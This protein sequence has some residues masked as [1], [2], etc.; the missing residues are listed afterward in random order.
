MSTPR[1]WTPEEQAEADR[2]H[3]LGW[4]DNRIARKIGRNQSAVLGRRDYRRPDIAARDKLIPTPRRCLH[5]GESFTASE[6]PSI[7]RI[8]DPCRP[9]VETRKR[10]LG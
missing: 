9:L 7:R 10:S 2:L 5:C 3:N 4:T 6:P 8:C 1:R